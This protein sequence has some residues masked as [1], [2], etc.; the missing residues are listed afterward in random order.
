MLRVAK[1]NAF[2]FSRAVDGKIIFFNHNQGPLYYCIVL[3]F[4]ALLCW[5][6]SPAGVVAISL[7]CGGDGLADIVGRRFGTVRD[8]M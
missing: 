5:R 8:F 1:G 2:M 4:V 7:M 6:D 3:I